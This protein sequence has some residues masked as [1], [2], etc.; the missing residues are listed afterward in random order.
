M[1]HRRAEMISIRVLTRST[2]PVLRSHRETDHRGCDHHAVLRRRM[3]VEH[4]GLHHSPS[5]YLDS[6]SDHRRT[7]RG[8][9]TGFRPDRCT[10]R[11][12]I[13]GHPHRGWHHRWE[14]SGGVGCPLLVLDPRL[15][16]VPQG[17]LGGRRVKRPAGYQSHRCLNHR[18]RPVGFRIGHSRRMGDHRIPEH[19]R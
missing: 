16:D 17:E 3:L 14:K 7:T 13:H 2:V 19:R 5:D 12:E 6:R 11:T 4:P 15:S 1:P 10:G 9:T 8:G 18:S